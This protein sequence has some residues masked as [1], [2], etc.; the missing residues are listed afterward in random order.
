MKKIFFGQGMDYLNKEQIVN[1]H[2][3]VEQIFAPFGF[4]VISAFDPKE[5]KDFELLN[6][7]EKAEIIVEKDLEL[8]K[9]CDLC[10]FDLS[11]ENRNYVGC[12]FEIT[13]AYQL[14]MPIFAY[15]GETKFDERIWLVYHVKNLYKELDQAKEG[16]VNYEFK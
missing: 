10:L 15:V 9:S 8:L 12:F 13:Y 5:R 11:I 14:D 16:I 3:K 4:K 6:V 1:N 2:K 7:K